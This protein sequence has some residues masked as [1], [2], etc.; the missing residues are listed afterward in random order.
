MNT[1]LIKVHVS[2][3]FKAYCNVEQATIYFLYTDELCFKLEKVEV[4]LPGGSE[5]GS[6]QVL[7]Y[8]HD[9]NLLGNNIK[10]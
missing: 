10:L 7:V 3:E 1:V 5:M 2:D 8:V 4:L 9:M 6:D